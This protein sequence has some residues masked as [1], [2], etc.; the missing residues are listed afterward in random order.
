MDEWP[1]FRKRRYV[2]QLVFV[3]LTPWV[4]GAIAY[5]FPFAGWVLSRMDLWAD[6]MGG[7]ILV[8]FYS[9]GF[10]AILSLPI[11]F[12][13]GIGRLIRYREYRVSWYGWMWPFLMWVDLCAVAPVIG[14]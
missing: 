4:L 11:L 9:F 10:P 1:S 5:S 12:L 6:W 3:L 13:F 2:L 8:G 7:V 14:H